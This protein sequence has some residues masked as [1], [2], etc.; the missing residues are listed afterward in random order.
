VKEAS[1]CAVVGDEVGVGAGF[2]DAAVFEY[3]DAVGE[4]DGG[5]S[6]GDEQDG[7]VG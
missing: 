2:G 1:Q 4:A 6:V 7:G 3:D 5:G